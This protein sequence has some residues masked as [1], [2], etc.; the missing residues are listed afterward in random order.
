[1][2]S[3]PLQ[4]IKLLIQYAVV[5]DEFRDMLATSL[6]HGGEPRAADWAIDF[7]TIP[8]ACAVPIASKP[9]VVTDS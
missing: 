3:F 1:M 9:E 7:R 8:K 2:T 4:D 6:G 5:V